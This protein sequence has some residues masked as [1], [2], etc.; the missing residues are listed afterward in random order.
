MNN[1]GDSLAAALIFMLFL[2]GAA[3]QNTPD[4]INVS[5]TTKEAI[6]STSKRDL[7]VTYQRVT[8]T[9]Y[10]RRL[11]EYFA[12]DISRF[13]ER[14]NKDGDL[15][16]QITL[17]IPLDQP[18][19]TRAE[20]AWCSSFN[21][22]NPVCQQLF[23]R[24]SQLLVADYKRKFFKKDNQNSNP[25]TTTKKI[26]KPSPKKGGKPAKGGKNTV[27]PPPTGRKNK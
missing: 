12:T 8:G 1:C 9:V 26:H 13:A 19:L 24:V 25:T 4:S 23:P 14:Y 7:L 20:R 3:S 21:Q 5:I 15:A 16:V 10:I 22:R 18:P 27:I 11:A 6:I 17:S 2:R